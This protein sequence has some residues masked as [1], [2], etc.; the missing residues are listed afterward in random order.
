MEKAPATSNISSLPKIQVD[1][2][3]IAVDAMRRSIEATIEFEQLRSR[4]RGEKMRSLI[5]VG[6]SRAEALNIIMSDK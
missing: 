6:F 3:R 5:S 2:V 4:I 1:E